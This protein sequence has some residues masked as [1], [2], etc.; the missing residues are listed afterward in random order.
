MRRIASFAAAS[1]C[2]LLLQG[3]LVGPKYH[4]PNVPVP[5]VYRGDATPAQAAS[6]DR[7][8]GER[9]WK[10]IFPDPVL[11]NLIQTALKQ[12][13]DLKIA[14][15]RI[16]QQRAVLGATLSQ[17]FPSLAGSAGYT[18]ERLSH[19][20]L[21]SD[22]TTG[23]PYY[24]A[25]NIGLNT[26]W[27]I[28]FWGRYRRQTEAARATMLA[29]EFAR[30]AVVV[31][32]ISSVATSYFSLLEMR[33]EV[34]IVQQ[35]LQIRRHSLTLTKARE[36]HGVASMLDVRQAQTLVTEAQQTLTKLQENIQDEENGLSIL[37]G[38]NPERIATQANISEVKIPKIPP[39]LPSALLR[40]RPDIAEAEQNLISAN[41]D[42]GAA[43]ADYFPNI[44]LTAQ[45]G[46]ES[47][48]LH[49]LFTGSSLL[50][51]V[52][53]TVNLPIFTAGRIRSEVQQAK[54][55]QKQYLLRY[56][57]TIQQAF[58]DV[59][60][61]LNER[62]K[63]Q[64]YLLE[65]QALVK[66]ADGAAMLSRARYTGGV[67]TYL[68]VLDSERSSLAARQDLLRA[69]RDELDIEVQLYTALGGGWR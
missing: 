26:Q 23:D 65:Q 45:Y 68:E 37:L 53:P 55:I 34:Q 18:S 7:T 27:Q 10:E 50:W 69:K 33:S 46:V 15:A 42:I 5:P 43:E 9:S 4:R 6:S 44:G 24:S 64:T 54:A 62:A 38:E 49:R 66:E 48:A 2:T 39:G 30:R 22:S 21:P 36:E 3:C 52:Q 56:E 20:G 13:F 40:R 1:L 32:L 35:D 67:T 16:E 31:S 47:I 63:Q 17:F 59:A 14:A 25:S 19:T 8:F 41:A 29:T 51:V 28:D 60:N 58:R 12:N 11:Q 57:R 61:A